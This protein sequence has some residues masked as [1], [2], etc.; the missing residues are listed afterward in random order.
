MGDRGNIAVRQPRSGTSIYLYSHLGGTELPEV[1]QKA[2]AKRWRWDD[3]EY[4][5]RIIFDEMTMGD[6]GAETG[7]GIGVAPPDNEH[8]ILEVNC[9]TQYVNVQRTGRGWTFEEYIALA[10]PISEVERGYRE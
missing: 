5:T 3:H 1:L 4:L 9:D 2:L 7:F 8:P 10:D 6:Q